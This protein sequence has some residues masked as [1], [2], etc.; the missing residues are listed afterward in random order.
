M[1]CFCIPVLKAHFE[2]GSTEKGI[3]LSP[4][5]CYFS[6]FREDPFLEKSKQY[7]ETLSPKREH[8]LLSECAPFHKVANQF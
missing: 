5:G 3:T 8:P 4:K 7:F 1:S 2:S 6:P